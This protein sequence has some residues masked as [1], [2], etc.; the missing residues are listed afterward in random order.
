MSEIN[1]EVSGVEC[2]TLLL[3][4]SFFRFLL[5]SR[6]N[7]NFS[8]YFLYPSRNLPEFSPFIK[9]SCMQTGPIFLLVFL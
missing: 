5:C 8:F 3:L 4:V 1:I 7:Q 6:K 9:M 2:D